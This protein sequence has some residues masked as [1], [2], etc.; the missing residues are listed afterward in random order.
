MARPQASLT[1][2]TGSA[3]GSSASIA[4]DANFFDDKIL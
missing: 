4:Y 2:Q 1:M 3:D